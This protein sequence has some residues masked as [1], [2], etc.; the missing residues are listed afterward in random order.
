MVVLALDISLNCSGFAVLDCYNGDV[1]LLCKGHINNKNI[2][3]SRIGEKLVNIHKHITE[4]IREYKPDVIVR[5]KSFSNSHIA[6][7]Q[8]LQ[9]CNGVVHEVA[10]EYG[11]EITEIAPTTIKKQITGNGK[12]DKSDVA[13]R[14]KY[15]VG[16]KVY[17]TDDESDAT[18]CGITYLIQ[19]GFIERKY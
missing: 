9:M 4:L 11:H 14:L 17:R 19:K 7:G 5:E 12:A 1:E 6:S 18:G 8:K 16:D 3:A 2:K 15:Y 10:G 13:E